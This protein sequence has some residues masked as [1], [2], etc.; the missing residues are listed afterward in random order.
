MSPSHANQLNHKYAPQV[1]S[2]PVYVGADV[3]SLVI[4]SVQ[5]RFFF[6]SN[7]RFISWDLATC[8]LPRFIN[9]TTGLPQPFDLIHMRDVIMHLPLQKATA[10]VENILASGA[11]YFI[12]TTFPG[13]KNINISA[14]SWYKNDME[15]HPFNFPAPSKCAR[16][17]AKNFCLW[18]LLKVRTALNGRR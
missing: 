10:I 13:N 8:P 11:T 15:Q 7:K 18:N 12:T 17:R 9:T 4:E 1:D 2:L 5:K 6:H 16:Y 3:S 14:G